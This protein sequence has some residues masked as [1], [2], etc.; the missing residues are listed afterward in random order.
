M[1]IRTIIVDDEERGISALQK[2]IE[3]YCKDVKVE[4]TAT[5]ITD[6]ENKINNIRANSI[7]FIF[8][9][10]DISCS[11][12]NFHIFTIVFDKLLQSRNA[13]FF[14]INDNCSYA[15]IMLI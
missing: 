2:L 7:N 15:H 8:S 12:F 1:S 4:A 3:N 6:A 10:C 9:I 5:D 11:S 13:P 14:I